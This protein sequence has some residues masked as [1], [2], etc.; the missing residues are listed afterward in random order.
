[1]VEVVVSRSGSC[2]PKIAKPR[3]NG[4][5]VLNIKDV[6]AATMEA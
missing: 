3:D 5:A 6:P 4:F 2:E 1:M